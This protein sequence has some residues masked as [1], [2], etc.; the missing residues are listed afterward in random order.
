MLLNVF[1]LVYVWV[2]GLSVCLVGV[3]GVVLSV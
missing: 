3:L 2:G 1:F